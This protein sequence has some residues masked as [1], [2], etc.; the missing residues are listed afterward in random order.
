MV[1]VVVASSGV[2]SLGVYKQVSIVLHV[3]NT[4]DLRN[5]S[6][7]NAQRLCP[8]AAAYIMVLLVLVP[9][10]F[11]YIH[12]DPPPPT[13]LPDNSSSFLTF[14]MPPLLNHDLPLRNSE[15]ENTLRKVFQRVKGARG[16]VRLQGFS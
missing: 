10:M 8:H 4:T 11:M 13:V 15:V 6:S 1:N 2:I 7:E 9:A 16:E 12:F 5:R 3:V 14:V